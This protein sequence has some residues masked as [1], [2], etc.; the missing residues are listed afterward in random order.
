[1]RLAR[2][3][4]WGAG[5]SVP[6]RSRF[7]SAVVPR[8]VPSELAA[9]DVPGYLADACHEWARPGHDLV[10]LSLPPLFVYG[11][12]R[13]G[14]PNAAK[15]PGRVRLGRYVTVSAWP[16]ML[17]GER[18][19]PCLFP[20]RG[21]GV[22]VAGEL[23]DLDLAGFEQL[24][25]LERVSAPDGYRRRRILVG[26]EAGAEPIAAHTYFKARAA[27]PERL[28]SR[29]NGSS[30]RRAPQRCRLFG[31]YGLACI[32]PSSRQHSPF[33]RRRR[34]RTPRPSCSRP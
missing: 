15:N 13:S 33:P 24:D 29:C 28:R 18:A 30:R 10:T 25:A 14:Y 12:L 1:M 23:V 22:L 11:T 17:C 3:G 2:A 8:A 6:P 4:K 20:E 32:P 19:S 21:N 16:L 9:A 26:G 27:A 34:W 7:A 31:R 5:P